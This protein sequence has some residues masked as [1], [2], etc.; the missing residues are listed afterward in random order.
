MRDKNICVDKKELTKFLF[1]LGQM[2][3]VK[4]CGFTVAGVA[5]S[6]SIAEHSYR[7][8]EIAFILAKMEGANPYK[9]SFMVLIHDNGE[10]RINDAHRIVRRYINT[11]KGERKVALDQ[12]KRLPNNI[13]KDFKE[14][15]LEFEDRK[16][17][18]AKCAKDADYLEQAVAAKEQIDIGYKGC[19]DWIIN[20]KKALMTDSTK[21]LL[22]EIEN[23]DRNEWYSGLK[24]MKKQK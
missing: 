23:M 1:E 13:E 22:L 4:H 10:A 2:W 17:L 21:E 5:N 24:K 15:Y 12:F 8:A 16:T 3:R 18:E 19:R 11:D 7:A 6:E 14:V 20:I 9:T